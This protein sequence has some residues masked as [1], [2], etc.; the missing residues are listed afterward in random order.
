MATDINPSALLDF[1]KAIASGGQSK[2]GARLATV[3]RIDESGTAYVQLP[4]GEETPI[5]TTGAAYSIGDVV[6]VSMYGGKLRTVDNISAP[7]V[8]ERVVRAAIRPVSKAAELAKAAASEADRV[9][10]AIN[11]HFWADDSGIHVTEADHDATTEHNILINSLG[12]LLRKA[13]NYLVSI[14]QSAIA[15]YDGLG[16]SASNVVAQFGSSG[17]TIGK[18]DTAHQEMDY[19]TWR[20]KDKNQ[21]VYAEVIDNRVTDGYATIVQSYPF[22]YVTSSNEF[23]LYLTAS[24]VTGVVFNN[25]SADTTIPSSGYTL[26][27]DGSRYYVT[28]QWSYLS[29]N[30]TVKI[31]YKTASDAA[32]S[33]TFGSR[34]DGDS[35][36]KG[37]MSFAEGRDVEASGPVSH[38]EGYDTHAVGTYAHAEGRST[39]ATGW[40][41]H[42]EGNNTVASGDRAHAGGWGTVAAANNQTAIGKFNIVDDPTD[43]TSLAFIVGNG[44]SDSNRSNALELDWNGNLTLKGKVASASLPSA[45][46][47]QAGIVQLSNS[48][49]S[50]STSLAATANS[51]RAVAADLS[52]ESAMRQQLGTDLSNLSSKVTLSGNFTNA[53]I[54]FGYVTGSALTVQ[55]YGILPGFASGVTVTGTGAFTLRG[56][57]GATLS[58]S[59]AAANITTGFVSGYKN[60]LDLRFTL[61]TA[62]AGGNNTSLAG[63]VNGL[64]LKFT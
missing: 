28:V 10:T 64:T 18:T 13:T 55:L 48:T 62:F 43:G 42:A 5:A 23:D 47:S 14:T 15:F 31:T 34:L 46:T 22:W 54:V 29:T 24:T 53:L 26:T 21:N 2:S 52:T 9:A 36:V 57:S 60:L 51:V 4:G 3:T 35:A 32:K 30:G 11:Q 40:A 6:S 37:P 56:G 45:S 1:A 25:G 38:A 7:S 44:T 12:I 16:N 50:T 33:F 20:M 8:P 19:R 41:S 39:T 17:A 58:V 27:V 59:V 61:S 63:F 49:S